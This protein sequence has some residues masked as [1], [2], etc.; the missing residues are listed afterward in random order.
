MTWAVLV[1]IILVSLL[2]ILLT[3]LPTGT[4]NWL[5]GIFETHSKLNEKDVTITISGMRLEG[6]EKLSIINYFNEAIFIKKHYIHPGTEQIFLHPVN[7]G[8]PIVIDVKSRNKNVRLW[9]YNYNDR[10]DV[11]K[12]NKKKVIAYSLI[13]ESLQNSFLAVHG[14]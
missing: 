14:S 9:I 8:T 5:I 4:V 12:L 3:C 11:V 1:P 2:K 7:S 6:E 13:S 10:I